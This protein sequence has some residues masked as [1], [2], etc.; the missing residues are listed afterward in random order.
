MFAGGTAGSVVGSVRKLIGKSGGRS[1]EEAGGGKSSAGGRS[2]EEPP[3]QSEP[4]SD[5]DMMS[6]RSNEVTRHVPII[7]HW[8][9]CP[10]FVSLREAISSFHVPPHIMAPRGIPSHATIVATGKTAPWFH[11]CCSAIFCVS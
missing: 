8:A 3:A 5:K 11:N 4:I 6:S 10:V 1:R 9:W 2:R 7:A